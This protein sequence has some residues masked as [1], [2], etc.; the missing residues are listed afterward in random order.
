MASYRVREGSITAADSFTAL[1]SLYG[2]ST[3]SSVQVPA[4]SSAIVG[5]IASVS[6]DSA[7][8]GAATFALQLTGDGL[9]EQQTITVGSAGVDGTPA[10]NGMTNAPFSLDVA[11]PVTAS[12]QVSIAGAMDVDVGTAQMSVTLVFA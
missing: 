12:N 2:Q 7:T 5:I 1:T 10:S 3:T 9:S 4:G 8:N 6:M 11:I